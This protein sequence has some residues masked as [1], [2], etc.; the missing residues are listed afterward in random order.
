MKQA[1]LGGEKMQRKYKLTDHLKFI[2]TS[3]IG[4]FF[5]ITPVK[6]ED[7]YTIPIGLLEDWVQDLL[8]NQLSAIM[9]VIIT[10]IPVCAKFIGE[11]IMYISPFFHHSFYV[12]PFWTI[13]R[14]IAAVFAVMVFF[15]LGPEAIHGVATGQELLDGLLHVLFAV[16][17]FAG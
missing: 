14:V 9:M 5:F 2:I 15:Q 4:I 3:L 7:G 12:T 16:F 8:A 6:I 1:L 11:E 13:T 10:I 17:L